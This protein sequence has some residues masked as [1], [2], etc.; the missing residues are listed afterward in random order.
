MRDPLK[1]TEVNHDNPDGL[2]LEYSN[3]VAG[4]LASK[5]GMLAAIA[6]TEEDE[7]GCEPSAEEIA[8]D[9]KLAAFTPLKDKPRA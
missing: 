2:E 3:R 9:P 1:G 8:R 5:S 4:G 7:D 6:G